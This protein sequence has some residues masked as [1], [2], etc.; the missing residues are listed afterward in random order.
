M[1]NPTKHTKFSVKELS[2][3]VPEVA[4]VEAGAILAESIPVTMTNVANSID[5]SYSAT[6]EDNG[7]AGALDGQPGVIYA[8]P[9]GMAVRVAIANVDTIEHAS[10][11]PEATDTAALTLWRNSEAVGYGDEG[12]N[13]HVSE[14]AVENSLDTIVAGLNEGDVLRVGFTFTGE[15]NGDLD[16]AP[17]VMTIT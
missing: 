10:T 8:G 12:F 16:V 1:P 3:T 2:G 7:T 14:I 5:F 4:L 15:V 17:G 11:P 6:A 13:A 9:S